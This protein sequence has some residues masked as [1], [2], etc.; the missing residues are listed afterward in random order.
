M[1][2][3]DSSH[4]GAVIDAAV[5]KATPTTLGTSEVSKCVTVDAS[6]DLIVPDSDKFKFGAGSDMQL[7]HDGSNS[8]IQQSGTGALKLATE[9]SGK[10]VS[11]G[12]TTS[13]TTVNDNLTVTGNLYTA[14]GTGVVI[15]HTAQE[16]TSIGDGDTDLVPEFQML[17]TAM[18]DSSILLGCWADTGATAGAPSLCFVKSRNA[19]IGSHTVVNDND[20]IGNIIWLGDDGTDLE[21]P[22]AQIQGEVDGDPGT[23]DMPGRLLFFTTPDGGETLTESMR[24]DSSGNTFLNGLY[25]MRYNDAFSFTS[26]T[27]K[28]YNFTIATTGGVA[29]FTYRIHASS[30]RDDEADY[31]FALWQGQLRFRN[32]ANAIDHHANTTTHNAN[33]NST[34]ALGIARADDNDI[35]FTVTY[36]T[37]AT[38]YGHTHIELISTGKISLT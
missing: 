1:A 22:I 26:E 30:A 17:G 38:S 10:A 11:I 14:N 20:Q 31:A 6:G 18:A 34:V 36:N 2:N 12:H 9:D 15:G 7:Y 13:E 4:T 24:I 3:Y 16:T 19:T 5:T 25:V 32:S 27:A 37:S 29:G 28:A 21:S 33:A 23:G 35:T 8:F